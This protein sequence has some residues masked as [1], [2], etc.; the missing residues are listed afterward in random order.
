MLINIS[1]D[2][3][4]PTDEWNE[5]EWLK[6][7]K[8]FGILD[9]VF[10]DGV[11]IEVDPCKIDVKG[12]LNGQLMLSLLGTENEYLKFGYT[13]DGKMFNL[14]H[15]RNNQVTR[16]AIIYIQDPFESLL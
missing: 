4:V 7:V 11:C 15:H 10:W 2:I 5:E 13:D 8:S 14:Y 9:I 16:V 12:M 6:D 3:I 1:K